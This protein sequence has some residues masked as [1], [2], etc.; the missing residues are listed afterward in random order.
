MAATSRRMF[1]SIPADPLPASLVQM[2]IPVV[3]SGR[4]LGRASVDVPYVDVDQIGGV[5]SAVQH[6]LD[7]GRKR[8]A[9]I[10]GPQDMPAGV[11]RL[12]GYRQALRDSTRRS[13][14]ALGTHPRS[15]AVA[16][17]HC[18]TTTQ[19]DALF[20]PPT[21]WRRR[22]AAL[23]ESARR[24]PNTWVVGFDD[25][26][27][28]LHRAAADHRSPADPPQI[29]RGW[30]AICS[31]CRPRDVDPV[32]LLLQSGDPNRVAPLPAPPAGT[33]RRHRGRM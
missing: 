31:L 15:G 12:T 22:A 26:E 33:S 3:C 16:M 7:T 13:I 10:A 1:A 21:S 4:P 20:V 30:P 14:V 19:L 5:V 23:H 25:I 29:G 18:S 24:C 11:D 2:G 28:P 27:M 6:L 17:R 32:V 9:T 8:I